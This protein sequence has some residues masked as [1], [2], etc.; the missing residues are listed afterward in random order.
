MSSDEDTGPDDCCLID[1]ARPPKADGPPYAMGGGVRGRP[2]GPRWAP[3][4]PSRRGS[5]DS[6]GPLVASH[7]VVLS[8][9]RGLADWW[10]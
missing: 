7:G 10:A 6:A 2:P 9:A 1:A 4:P 5:S 3:M 8:C